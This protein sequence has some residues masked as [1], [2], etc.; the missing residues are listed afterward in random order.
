[1]VSHKQMVVWLVR[2]S[3]S[4]KGGTRG[5]DVARPGDDSRPFL[6]E[7]E[8]L[9][10]GVCASHWFASWFA[11]HSGASCCWVQLY[12]WG[13][14]RGSLGAWDGLARW[15]QRDPICKENTAVGASGCETSINLRVI[16]ELVSQRIFSIQIMAGGG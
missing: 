4:G 12:I 2:R 5:E 14:G 15:R 11:R 1:M 8:N 7:P 3:S 16:I 9:R 13:V 10:R 6:R